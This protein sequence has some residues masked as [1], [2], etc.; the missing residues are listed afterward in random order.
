VIERV[1]LIAVFNVERRS[2]GEWYYNSAARWDPENEMTR[3]FRIG[4]LTNSLVQGAPRA[5]LGDSRRRFFAR[6]KPSS[7]SKE[8]GHLGEP[9]LAA[10]G[11]F[12]DRNANL[13]TIASQVLEQEVLNRLTERAWG[14]RRQFRSAENNEIRREALEAIK[15]AAEEFSGAALTTILLKR[16]LVD[17]VTGKCKAKELDK[18]IADHFRGNLIRAELYRGRPNRDGLRDLGIAF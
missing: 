10:I 8:V 1:P 17:F 13:H 2:N 15:T 7:V 3:R 16:A 5:G 18:A 9:T 6:V 11:H 14:I 12:C 4:G